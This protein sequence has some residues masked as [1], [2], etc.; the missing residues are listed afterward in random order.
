MPATS[1]KLV[2]RAGLTLLVSAILAA[3]G[4]TASIAADVSIE[5]T[6]TSSV[7]YDPYDP[8]HGACT[9]IDVPDM[10]AR[11]FR[12]ASGGVTMFAL[13]YVNRALRGPDADHVVIDCHVV[14][15]SPLD[16]DP[17]KYADW[18]WLTSTWTRDG[19]HVSAVVHQ[20]YHADAHGRCA[21]KTML[22]CWYNTLLAFHSD[23]G[24]V[25]F[26]KSRPVVVASSPFTQDVDQGRHRGFFQPSNMFSDGTFVYVMAA[27]TGWP[28]QDAGTCLFRT[29]N[30]ADSSL[31][32]AYDGHRFSIRY[33][34]PYRTKA[35]PRP[36]QKIEPFSYAVGGVV[37]HEA[38][39]TWI[40]VFEAPAVGPFPVSGFYYATSKDLLHWSYAK[41]LLAT[42]T[43]G[44][45]LCKAVPAVADYPS[46]LDS[47][48]PSR[49]FDVIGDHPMLYYTRI[50]VANCQ[51]GARK[52]VR[53]PIELT[54][55][56]PR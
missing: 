1:L 19:T 5:L 18:Y 47:Q 52:L 4:Q 42:P 31:W 44:T 43:V 53:R 33:S 48:S 23:D 54:L 12:N 25:N 34:D 40:A 7:V 20:E 28:G 50:E 21:F 55:G 35:A 8:A 15:D 11:A 17:A 39:K 27:T 51:L 22:E 32:R 41:I 13:H 56:D 49:N 36:C 38:S 14:L 26:T 24:G 3:A 45:D 2:C 6:G 9:P 46:I 29:T 30:P 10:P 37:R 16:A